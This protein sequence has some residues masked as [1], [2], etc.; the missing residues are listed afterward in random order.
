[1]F[2]FCGINN[3]TLLQE[4]RIALLQ[5][6][7]EDAAHINSEFMQV[8]DSLI[9]KRKVASEHDIKRLPRISFSVEIISDAKA[10]VELRG[11]CVYVSPPPHHAFNADYLS[12]QIKLPKVTTPATMAFFVPPLTSMPVYCFT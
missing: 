2:Y 7:S 3:I 6:N 9:G 12:G 8:K 5:S 1:M 11:D 10:Y 4:R